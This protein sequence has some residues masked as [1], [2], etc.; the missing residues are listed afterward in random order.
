M[1]VTQWAI[2]HGFVCALG[3]SAIVS[4]SSCGS[5]DSE[6]GARAPEVD[7]GVARQALSTTLIAS[8]DATIY[9]DA[10]GNAGDFTA[11]LM[12]G[13]GKSPFVRRSLVKFDLSSI[14]SAATIT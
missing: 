14:P 12:V 11:S 6:N 3:V 1:D 2:K 8:A 4:T 9:Q 13:F 5:S 10:Q 7:V